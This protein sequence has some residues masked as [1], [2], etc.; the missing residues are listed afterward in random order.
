MALYAT[1]GFGTGAPI[2][3]K[4]YNKGELHTRV[5]PLF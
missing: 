2:L 4:N 1:T 5:R 3:F